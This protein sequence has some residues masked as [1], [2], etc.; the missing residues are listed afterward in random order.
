MYFRACYFFSLPLFLLTPLLKHPFSH[1]IRIISHSQTTQNVPISVVF[2]THDLTACTTATV[3]DKCP[4]VQARGY[5]LNHR[6]KLIA[7]KQH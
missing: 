6:F 5:A 1:I 2:V 7:H 4:N 3:I